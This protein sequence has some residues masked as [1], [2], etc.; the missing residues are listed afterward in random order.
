LKDKK[1]LIIAAASA[2]IVI[3]LLFIFLPSG[4]KSDEGPEVISMRAKV[5]SP[6]PVETQTLP[7][8]TAPGAPA[9]DIAQPGAPSPAPMGAAPVH[10]PPVAPVKT[11]EPAPVVQPKAVVATETPAAPAVKKEQ[12]KSQEPVK[13][14][15]VKKASKPAVKKAKADSASKPWAIN[16]ASFASLPEAQSLAGAL[17]KAGYNSYITPFSMDDVQWQRVRV[18]FFSN[19]E[20]A[21]SAGVAI[22]TKFRV[23]SPW[24]VRPDTAERKAH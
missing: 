21:Q 12:P 15:A 7:E 1:I 9:A 13:K 4:K 22:Q 11:A 16:V 24:I 18:G 19:R 5:E 14:A 17:K 6:A 23:E 10:A 3:A 20:E 2:V 8:E